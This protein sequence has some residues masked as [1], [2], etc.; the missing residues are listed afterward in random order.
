MSPYV[1]HEP[2]RHARPLWLI[3]DGELE[4]FLAQQPAPVGAWVRAQGFR[5]ES[6]RLMAVPTPGGDI[7]GV[8]VGTGGA[9]AS[10]RAIAAGLPE[11]L[12]AG[13]YAVDALPDAARAAFV[14][15][16][17][18]GRYRFE[19]YK[20]PAPPAAQLMLP[21]GFEA[22][23]IERQVA[24]DRLVRDL[25]NTP[26]A[27]LDPAA[28]A[29]AVRHRVQTAAL[30]LQ[31]LQTLELAVAAVDLTQVMAATADQAS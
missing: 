10:L 31:E 18:L 4:S 23:A 21:A 5:A 22:A 3:A 11:R 29:A 26:A 12:P 28:L 20:A 6:G 24:A 16:W 7:L 15:G 14:L 8:L 30:V 27:D 17:G 25:I 1:V 9:G 13:V 19:R 2:S